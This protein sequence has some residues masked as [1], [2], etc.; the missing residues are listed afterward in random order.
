MANVIASLW[1]FVK[2]ICQN[3]RAPDK[4]SRNL[5]L[6]M[7]K[8]LS[9][10]S[11]FEIEKKNRNEWDPYYNCCVHPMYC[12][13]VCGCNIVR[14]AG[15]SSSVYLSQSTCHS[16]SSEN[17]LIQTDSRCLSTAYTP[18]GAS[19]KVYDAKIYFNWTTVPSFVCTV[20][21]LERLGRRSGM[22]WGM[23]HTQAWLNLKQ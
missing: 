16:F 2:L 7:Y 17:D 21:V 15:V 6:Y 9:F 14:A 4:V 5:Y 13:C 12:E 22:A 3:D 1:P 8:F 19:I 10:Y 23:R 20:R 11:P 18:H